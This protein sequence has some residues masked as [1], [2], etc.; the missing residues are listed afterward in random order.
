MIDPLTEQLIRPS[1]AVKLYPTGRDG[2]PIHVSV[3]YRDMKYG[4]NGILL[5]SLRTP[6]LATSREAVV[7]FFYKLTSASASLG[8]R[9]PVKKTRAVRERADRRVE[10]ALDQLG[11]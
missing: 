8:S 9:E 6:R 3:V 10:R 1:N 2:K 4:R 7:R 11:I 5:E